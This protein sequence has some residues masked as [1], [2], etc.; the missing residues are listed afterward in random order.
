MT[1][2]TYNYDEIRQG[3]FVP[4]IHDGNPVNYI[5]NNSINLRLRLSWSEKTSDK[6]LRRYYLT[7]FYPRINLVG[8]YGQYSI[9]GYHSDYFKLH[10]AVK[11]LV[12]IGFMRFKYV[13]EAGYIFGKVPFPMLEFIRGNDSY[14]DAKYRFNLLNNA[15]SA[16]DKYASIM[17]EHHFNGLIMNKIP[18]IKKLN[19]RLVMS[20]KYFAGTLSDRHQQVLEYPWD[21]HIPGNQYLEL[22]AGFENIFQLLRIEGIWRPVPAKYP[23]MPTYGIRIRFEF[24]M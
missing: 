1:K 10:L 16:L 2:L 5:Y 18:L 8:T 24:I 17:A 21:M 6:F 12:P 13:L 7:T 11:H 23:G 15:T 22:G 3:V 14:G 20:A 19:I 9:S 4:F